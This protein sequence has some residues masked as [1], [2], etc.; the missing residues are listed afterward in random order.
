M[1]ALAISGI[2][3]LSGFFSKDEIMWKTFENTGI[4]FYIIVLFIAALTAF[5]MFRLIGLAFFGKPRYDEKHIEPHESPKVMTVPLIILAILSVIGGFIGFPHYLG[6]PNVLDQWL[7]PVFKNAY[8]ITETYRHIGEQPVAI[9]L[10]F[11]IVSIVVAT[12]AI[13]I[14]FKK[15][16]TKEKFVEEKGFGKVLEKKYYLDEIYEASIVKP[17][18]F[19][20]E[21]FLW[22]I[23]DV[24]I[25]DGA[26]NG[27][28]NYFG[29]L[30][31]DWRKLQ[32]GVVQ[33]YATVAIAGVVLILL[34]ILFL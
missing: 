10:I 13:Y 7:K 16:S 8:A 21:K 17:I 32:S 11:V 30:S 14:S 12:I 28:A 1:G 26:V 29:K 6:I 5:Y 4:I 3:P 24:K 25:I 27:L 23:F 15:F 20:S 34:Y 33:D 31:L 9:E 19:T 22:N 2:P 18:E